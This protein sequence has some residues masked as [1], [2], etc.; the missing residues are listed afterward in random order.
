MHKFF[1]RKKGGFYCTN[2]L[3]VKKAKRKITVLNKAV[4]N[5]NNRNK[6]CIFL[7]CSKPSVQCKMNS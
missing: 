2:F 5:R 3:H 1:K 7:Y 4:N 6:H